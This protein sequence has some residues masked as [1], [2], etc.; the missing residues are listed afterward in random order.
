[1]EL[2]NEQEKKVKE[3]LKELDEELV[4]AKAEI[5][6]ILEKKSKLLAA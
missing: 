1:M 5:G 3:I 4:C 6:K 2:T